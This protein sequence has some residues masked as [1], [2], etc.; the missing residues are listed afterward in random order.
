MRFYPPLGPL[1]L[2][3]RTN[4]TLHGRSRFRPR[5][6]GTTF[7]TASPGQVG[8]MR[9]ISSARVARRFT[10]LRSAARCS[11]GMMLRGWK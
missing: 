7:S 8:E 6:C 11:T 4:A 1:G 3:Q 5:M 10:P 2:G 9:S